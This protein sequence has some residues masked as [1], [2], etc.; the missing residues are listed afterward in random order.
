MHRISSEFAGIDLGDKRLNDR[1]MAIVEVLGVDPS[2]SFPRAF[3]GATAE[4]EG[5][6]RF[7]EN[8]RVTSDAL[9]QPHLEETHRRCLE[10]GVVLAVHDTTAFGFGHG[11]SR[12]AKL[13]EN[14]KERGFY[15]HASLAVSSDGLRAPLG[16]I[17]LHTFER[18]TIGRPR[19]SKERRKDDNR[20]SKRWLAQSLEAE[21][22]LPNVSVIHVEDR[23]ADIYESLTAR[24]EKKMRFV[25]RGQSHRKL[26]VDGEPRKVD[27]FLREQPR[28]MTRTVSLSRRTGPPAS[29]GKKTNPPR[30]AREATLEIAAMTIT[31]RRPS[32]DGVDVP[33]SLTLNAVHLIEV[34]P[35]EGEEPVEWILFT[36]EP[37]DTD[38]QLDFV[39]DTYR[40]RWLIE[41]YFKALKTGCSY[42]AR[43]FETYEALLRVLGVFAVLAWNLLMLRHLER[44]N[45]TKPAAITAAQL[46][47]L[48]ARRLVTTDV[49]TSAEALRAIARLGGHIKWN[50]PPGWI[51][52]W[53]GY[54]KLCD[55]AEGFEVARSDQ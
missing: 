11:R 26:L 23:E 15:C 2:L 25:V 54:R 18:V 38:K 28:R 13:Q 29:K 37:I 36:T 49:P 6:Y 4:L 14:V 21:K 24:V 35:P 20:E 9:L 7:F 39:I 31:L 43:Q 40:A 22:R 45:D 12:L 3:G 19:G 10:G 44:H 53:R 51:V 52:I 42:E 48:K 1:A 27:E 41:E 30:E 33:A 50:G 47:I 5:V 17:G 34:P 8:D 32:D 55:L 16:I 46:A